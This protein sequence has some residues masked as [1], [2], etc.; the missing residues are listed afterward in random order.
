MEEASK[1]LDNY[2]F[3]TP[4][5]DVQRESE[6]ALIVKQILPKK[7]RHTLMPGTLTQ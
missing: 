5:P 4:L 3:T 6:V 7:L 2:V 1:E